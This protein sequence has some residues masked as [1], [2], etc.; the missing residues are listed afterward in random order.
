MDIIHTLLRV[1]KEQLALSGVQ[2]AL[3]PQR[4][5]LLLSRSVEHSGVNRGG[6]HW[7]HVHPSLGP[8]VHIF[9]GSI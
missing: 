5:Y 2:S 8:G 1:H 4:F 6:V 9:L 3:S 7:M